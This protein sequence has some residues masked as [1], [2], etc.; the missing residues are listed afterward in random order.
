[1]D[2]LQFKRFGPKLENKS[3]DFTGSGVPSVKFDDV[4]NFTVTDPDA[5]VSN[6]TE[7]MNGDWGSIEIDYTTNNDAK[8]KTNCHINMSDEDGMWISI[9]YAAQ[10]TTTKILIYTD[11][12]NEFTGASGRYLH[13]ANSDTT[14]TYRQGWNLI[15]FSKSAFTVATGN[16]NWANPVRSIQINIAGTPTPD[17]IVRI[18]GVWAES[19][20]TSKAKVVLGYD[21]AHGTSYLAHAVAKKYSVPL[22]H[23][24]IPHSLGTSNQLTASEVLEIQADGDS[25]CMHD[26]LDVDNYSTYQELYD[27]M[28]AV[29]DSF[30]SH[31]ISYHLHY[32]WPGGKYGLEADKTNAG[33]VEIFE[34]V[35]RDHGV[36]SARTVQGANKVF[37][38]AMNI[39]HIGANLSL[40][41]ANSLADVKS[42][43]DI[44]IAKGQL[45]FI[46]G[47]QI[48][49]TIDSLTW[50]IEDTTELIQYLNEKASKN[51]LDLLYHHEI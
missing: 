43:I 38:E 37:G 16:P 13:S 49:A 12:T 33:R 44:A 48:G 3:I 42:G 7:S 23:W 32:A 18:E 40:G 8:F 29:K 15:Y 9:W 46:Y 47:H 35:L 45:L 25:I 5:G 34:S 50:S 41:S 30:A 20:L 14:S 26:N 11:E 28:T 2:T 10:T 27:A 39:Y 31:G 36:L 22:T 51:E 21:D 19:A 17:S 1:M 24:I 6:S 4:A